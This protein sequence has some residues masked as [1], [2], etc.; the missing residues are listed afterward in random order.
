MTTRSRLSAQIILF[1]IT[2]IVIFGTGGF[3]ALC[4]GIYL[5]KQLPGFRSKN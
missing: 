3:L 1:V 2:G 5:I 4:V